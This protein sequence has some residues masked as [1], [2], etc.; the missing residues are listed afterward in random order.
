MPTEQVIEFELRVPGALWPYMY[1]YNSGA[2]AGGQG[3]QGN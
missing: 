1:S 2:P 3:V